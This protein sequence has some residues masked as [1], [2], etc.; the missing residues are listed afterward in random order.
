MQDIVENKLGI[1]TEIEFECCRRTGKFKRN[2]SKTIT[3]V[4]KLFRFEDKEIILQNAKKLKD[5]DIF[6]YE[7]FGKVTM[8]L[9][10]S[11]WENVLG[12][13]QQ[14]KM[15]CLNYKWVVV[16]DCR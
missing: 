6:I 3:I 10:K 11:P 15:V 8:E 5:T 9:Q 16:R 7:D 12:H 13:C 4:C 1:T 2:Q 14:N